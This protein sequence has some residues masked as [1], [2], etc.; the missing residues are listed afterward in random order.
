MKNKESLKDLFWLIVMAGMIFIIFIQ[1][2]EI[3]Q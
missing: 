1:I 3:P 2:T